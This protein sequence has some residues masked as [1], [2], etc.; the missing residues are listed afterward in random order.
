ME[1]TLEQFKLYIPD[2]T[3]DDTVLERYLVDSRRAVIRDGFPIT[4]PDFDELQRLYCLGLLQQDKVSGVISATSSGDA[5]EGISNISV[6]G[7]GIGF[8]GT[9][10]ASKMDRATGKIGYMADYMELVTKLRGLQDRIY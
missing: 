7:I 2:V 1:I 5:P 4:H 9:K 6:A 10:T 3:L 8:S